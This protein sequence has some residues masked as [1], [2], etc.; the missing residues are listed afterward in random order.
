MGIHYIHIYI[1]I[2]WGEVFFTT[3]TSTLLSEFD[4][5]KSS[6]RFVA[7]TTDVTLMNLQ[8]Q[9]HEP[10]I[11]G[12]D[13]STN[14][15]GTNASTATGERRWAMTSSPK[16]GGVTPS[17]ANWMGSISDAN[18]LEWEVS[19]STNLYHCM[20]IIHARKV[21]GIQRPARPR[22]IAAQRVMQA[23]RTKKTADAAE[24]MEHQ[25]MQNCFLK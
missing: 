10:P 13:L 17:Y 9:R 6:S 25:S 2:V 11:S 20:Y 7:A 24:F 19:I 15:R 14:H 16:D 4:K 12:R 22:A 23:N 8:Y 5:H 21:G 1:C 18:P 3:N